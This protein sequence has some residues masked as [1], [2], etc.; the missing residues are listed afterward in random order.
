MT[1][2]DATRLG[3]VAQIYDH[4][5]ARTLDDLGGGTVLDLRTSLALARRA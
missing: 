2:V 3:E 4:E 1:D 5:Q